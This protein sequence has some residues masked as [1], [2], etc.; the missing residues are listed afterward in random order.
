[1]HTGHVS[2]LRCQHVTCTLLKLCKKTLASLAP[3]KRAF[4]LPPLMHM[5]SLGL[6]LL[7]K[8]N[9]TLHSPKAMSCLHQTTKPHLF[10]EHTTGPARKG[11][12]RAIAQLPPEPYRAT[13]IQHSWLPLG[14]VGLSPIP[15]TKHLVPTSLK[16]LSTFR[17]SPLSAAPY[18]SNLG[19]CGRGLCPPEYGNKV[20]DFWGAR[21]PPAPK[22]LPP[23]HGL[24][25][26]VIGKGV[27]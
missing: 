2:M 4:N 6:L 3:P 8:G 10:S 21:A 11:A 16:G 1:M 24:A 19:L 12:I 5:I 18:N 14:H 9:S 23:F 27:C 13:C 20:V 7:L 17:K 26:G 25:C 15:T 22:H